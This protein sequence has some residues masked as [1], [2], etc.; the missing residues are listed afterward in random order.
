MVYTCQ[1]CQNF[2]TQPFG[3][4]VETKSKNPNNTNVNRNYRFATAPQAISSH[5]QEC[6]SPFFVAGP[7]WLGPLHDKTFVDKML[8]VVNAPD[9]NYAT[10]SRLKGM[11]T[12]ARS[13]SLL[14]D[15]F[16]HIFLTFSQEIDAPFYF[17]HAKTAG[18]FHS[19][20]PSID[21]FV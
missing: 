12:V 6:Q 8:D 20:C 9:A 16:H 11:L 4:M 15:C 21:V 5:C 18:C 3:R 14:S 1:F 13:V 17:T 10:S 2:V 7:M 19:N